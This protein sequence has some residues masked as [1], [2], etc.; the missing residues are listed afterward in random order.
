METRSR[1]KLGLTAKLDLP[2]LGNARSGCC[3]RRADTLNAPAVLAG[4]IATIADRR[5][6]QA[7][8]AASLSLVERASSRTPG[9]PT[10]N[11][12]AMLPRASIMIADGV[13]VDP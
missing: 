5:G 3:D 12:E 11:P 1:D 4:A 6:D 8:T 10:A 2:W 9:A 13:P 7:V